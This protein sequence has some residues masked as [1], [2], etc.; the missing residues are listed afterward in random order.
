MK[1]S[2]AG[3]CKCFGESGVKDLG[4]C[5]CCCINPRGAKWV[6]FVDVFALTIL[7]NPIRFAAAY[8]VF[9]SCYRNNRVFKFYAG[10][11]WCTFVLQTIILFVLL[12]TL[13][14]FHLQGAIP[15]I[16][17]GIKFSMSD[18]EDREEFDEQS[19]K[20]EESNVAWIMLS[21]TVLAVVITVLDFHYSKTVWFASKVDAATGKTGV[22]ELKKTRYFP[23]SDSEDEKAK[24]K[25]KEK[26]KE[27]ANEFDATHQQLATADMTRPVTDPDHTRTIQDLK[28]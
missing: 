13:I 27:A 15:N 6:V 23:D 18:I 16:V 17:E 24:K 12:I 19:T 14:V 3:C 11:R 28:A 7:F 22:L 1:N 2:K 20:F 21:Y 9:A 8:L 26:E 25:E 4:K 10:I 5:C